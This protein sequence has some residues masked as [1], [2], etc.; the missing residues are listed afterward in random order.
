MQRTGEGEVKYD[1][2]DLT[3]RAHDPAQLMRE[4]Q[5]GKRVDISIEGNTVEAR[6]LPPVQQ[7]RAH[8][9]GLSLDVGR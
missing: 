6:P 9:R 5:P 2:K 3:E 7:Q 1:L 4:L 8:D